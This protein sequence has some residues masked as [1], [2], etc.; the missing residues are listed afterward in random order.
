M[1]KPFFI[2]NKLGI[3]TYAVFDSDA[4]SKE[5]RSRTNRLLQQIAGVEKP[6]EY[7]FGCFSYYAAFEV[8]LEGYIEKICGDGWEQTFKEVADDMELDILDVCKTPQAVNRVVTKLRDVG[9]DF[10]MFREIVEKVDQLTA[11]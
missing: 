1:D 11:W 5:K 2:F 4:N 10:P 3:P 8:N 6:V 7:P 9:A